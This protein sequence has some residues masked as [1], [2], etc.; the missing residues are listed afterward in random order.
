MLLPLLLLGYLGNCGTFI[1]VSGHRC[2]KLLLVNTLP[3][4]PPT[5]YPPDLQIIYFELCNTETIDTPTPFL[6]KYTL[7]Y[8]YAYSFT[9]KA[10]NLWAK[11]K[12][13]ENN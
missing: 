2:C 13:K 10:H 9:R 12:N 11:Y 7:P 1:Y 6:P 5:L 4:H 3:P 8:A